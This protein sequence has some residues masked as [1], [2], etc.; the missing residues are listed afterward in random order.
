MTEKST[1]EIKKQAIE[2]YQKSQT[3][4][5]MEFARQQ[6]TLMLENMSTKNKVKFY[7]KYKPNQV[8]KY[9]EDPSNH[10][11]ELREVS[12]YLAISSPQYWRLVNYFPSIAILSPIIVPFDTEKMMKNIKKTTKILN[13]CQKVLDN[14]NVQHEFLKVLQTVFRED[15]YYGYEVETDVSY[16]VKTLDSRYCRPY[17][18]YDGCLSFQF[19]LSFFDNNNDPDVDKLLLYEQI[20]PEFIIKYNIYK[21]KGS[22]Y[23]WQEI[24][25]DRQICIKAQ[26]SFDFCCPPFIS[27]FNEAYDIS[28]YKDL[29]KAKVETDNTKFIGFNMET[30]KDT[31]N[32]DDFKLSEELMKSYFAFIQSCLGDKVGTFMTPMPFQDISFSDSGSNTVDNVSNAIKTFWSAT[33]VADVLV[34]ENKNA[35]TLKYSIK[36]DE[37]LLFNVYSQIERFLS[38]KFKQLS[39][40]YFKISLPHFT[41]INI[42][43]E[44]DKYLKASQYGYSGA[45]TV[46]QSALNFSQN[47]AQGLAFMENEIYKMQKNMM[48]VSSSYTMSG[49]EEG[50]ASEKDDGDLTESGQLSRDNSVNDNR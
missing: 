9:L 4:A 27:V 20:D 13:T 33:G 34:G 25:P 19:D 35:G 24:N 1:D 3:N 30:K 41:I 39:G 28:D 10:E 47:Q 15:I 18:N 32:P 42:G 22:S 2:E 36:T 29:N 26:E 7:N 8:D 40:N 31:N 48:P 46:V 44:F 16:Y 45:R 23:R 6:Q 43:D 17:G 11:K 49:S 37:A 14:M 50:G 21:E 12:R 38:R 5:I